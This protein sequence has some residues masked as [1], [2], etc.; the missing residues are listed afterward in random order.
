MTLQAVHST[1]QKQQNGNISCSSPLQ[2]TSHH[3]YSCSQ[4]KEMLTSLLAIQPRGCSVHWL[5][6]VKQKPYIGQTSWSASWP[7][8]VTLSLWITTHARLHPLT[9]KRGFQRTRV[10]A[11]YANNCL[12]VW[13][14]NS[15]SE[16][17]NHP[18]HD[19]ERARSQ[20]GWHQLPGGG[21]CLPFLNHVPNRD[22]AGSSAYSVSHHTTFPDNLLLGHSSGQ[23]ICLLSTTTVLKQQRLEHSPP[24]RFCKNKE[25]KMPLEVY[26]RQTT[27]KEED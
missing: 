5:R 18:P 24:L 2:S 8:L 7:Q 21:V 11:H 15:S 9:R 12:E 10:H 4:Q 20:G 17:G 23:L 6:G 13:L 14:Q 26:W 16:T 19:S 3:F 27:S 1:P 25:V 22:T